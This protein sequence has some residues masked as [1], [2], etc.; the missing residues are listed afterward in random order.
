MPHYPRS[1]TVHL[2]EPQCYG[3]M[4][5]QAVLQHSSMIHGRV[6]NTVGIFRVV[7]KASRRESEVVFGVL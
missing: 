4:R 6:S 5:Q 1:G 7:V 2:G 3:S